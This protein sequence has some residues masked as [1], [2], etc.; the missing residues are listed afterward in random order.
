LLPFLKL[1]ISEIGPIILAAAEQSVIAL[2]AQNMTGEE[3]RNEAFNRIKT[4]LISQGIVVGTSVINAA[5]E[6]AVAKFKSE[7]AVNTVTSGDM[8]LQ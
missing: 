6:A 3:K 2:A 5:I 8:P 7:G 1:F 4:N